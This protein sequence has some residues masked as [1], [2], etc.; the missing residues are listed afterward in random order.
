[1]KIR[2]VVAGAF[3]T[4][5]G[6]TLASIAF[7]LYLT[8]FA[9]YTI[10]GSLAVLIILLFWF[11][12]LGFMIMLGLQVNYILKRDYYGGINYEPKLS[13]F[14]HL[15]FLSKLTSFEKPKN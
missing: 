2:E 5:L 7:S 13:I 10:Y 11:Y 3:V 9:H 12:W 8:H 4:S 1:M 6:W 14:E 15:K